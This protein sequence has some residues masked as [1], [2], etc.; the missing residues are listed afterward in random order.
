MGQLFDSMVYEETDF[1]FRKLIESSLNANL[2]LKD[3]TIIFINQAGLDLFG[4][5]KK[6]DII[7]LSLDQYLH[8]DYHDICRE[9]LRKVT[10]A[11]EIA[12]LMEQKVIRK[13]GE[14]I[15][16]EIMANPYVHANQTF[17][18]ITIR[19]IT[20][21]KH[22]R[23]LLM[24]SE[25]LALIGELATGI[26]HDIRNPLT[27]IKGFLKLVES[28]KSGSYLGIIKSEIEQIEKISNELLYFAKPT[29]K[30]Y[31]RESINAILKES[32][33]LFSTQFFKRR[34]RLGFGGMVE[35]ELFVI[36]D[37][38][39]LKQ[40]FVNLVKNAIEAIGEKGEINLHF[41]KDDTHVSIGVEDNGNGIPKD[42]IQNIGQSF[43]SNKPGGTGLGLMM[44]YNIAANHNGALSFESE[45]GV[46]TTF[47]VRLPISS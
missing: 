17:P 30:K 13:T 42:K 19:D 26:V 40:L 41:E 36:G 16:V 44:A 23:Q 29:E 43:Y 24:Q 15:D 32:V 1:D 9:R 4:V 7:G 11:H 31:R 18:Y 37:K 34:I 39:Q 3:R 21:I 20:E 8:P 45:E 35:S 46:G 27:S 5:R 22:A 12:P 10:K 2:L 14:I 25:K 47:T 38:V 33:E 6:E 28:D